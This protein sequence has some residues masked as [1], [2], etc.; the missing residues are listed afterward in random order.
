MTRVKV[1]NQ[2]GNR[3]ALTALILAGL[4]AGCASSVTMAPP[5]IPVPLVNKI[6]VSV[7]LRLPEN[8][9]NFVHEESVYGREEWSISLGSSNRALFT[10]L[11]GH[12][13]ESVRVLEPGD[14]PKLMGLDALIEPSIDAFEFST[15]AQSRTEAFAVWIRYRLKVYDREGVLISN[16]PVAAYGKSQTTTLNKDDAL[17]RAAVLAMRDAAALMIMKFDKVTR[18]SELADEPGEVQAIAVKEADDDN[19]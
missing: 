9:D 3:S 5:K 11:F 15:P 7:G 4:L 12:M 16:W 8:F 18:I 14:D 19:T 10:Q 6:P 1:L 17:R 2:V 13:F